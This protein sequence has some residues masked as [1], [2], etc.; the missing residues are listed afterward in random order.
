[1]HLLKIINKHSC[2]IVTASAR[3]M[4]ESQSLLKPEAYATAVAALIASTV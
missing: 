2:L 3:D 1:M 4:L